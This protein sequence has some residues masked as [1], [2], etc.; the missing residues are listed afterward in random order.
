MGTATFV[1]SV[2]VATAP[3][4][5]K[6]VDPAYAFSGSHAGGP[7]NLLI[8]SA[9][10]PVPARPRPYRDPAYAFSGSHAGGPADLLIH[11]AGAVLPVGP[12]TYRNPAYAY[13]GSHAGGPANLLSRQTG[14]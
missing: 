7:A 9:G 13:S 2:L 4:F 14:R 1:A 8:R 10:V 5:A 3:A 12:R 6:N 11:P